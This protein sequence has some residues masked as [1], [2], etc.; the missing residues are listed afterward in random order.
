VFPKQTPSLLE[1]GTNGICWPILFQIPGKA[2]TCLIYAKIAF[3]KNL[4]GKFI[5]VPL[6]NP[7]ECTALLQAESLPVK[8]SLSL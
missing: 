8:A 4:R 2:R 1:E 6:N 7:R 3:Q 5:L